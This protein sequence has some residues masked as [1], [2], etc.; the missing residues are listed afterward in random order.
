MAGMIRQFIGYRDAG[1][2][3]TTLRS[4]VR[5]LAQMAPVS[6]QE[7]EKRVDI[8]LL[9]L[10]TIYGEPWLWVEPGASQ[11]WEAICLQ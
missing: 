5:R 10:N 9:L 6:P 11:R 2:P 1:V 4:E 8:G 3:M 7:R